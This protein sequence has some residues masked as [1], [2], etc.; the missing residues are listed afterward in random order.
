MEFYQSTRFDVVVGADVGKRSH[1]LFA[2][3]AASG[4]ALLKG[5]RGRSRGAASSRPPG[6]SPHGTST[7]YLLHA[8]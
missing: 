2:L 8:S 4:E 7:Q 3:D 1:H 6:A 5:R